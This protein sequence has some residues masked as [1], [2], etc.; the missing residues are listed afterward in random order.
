[1]SRKVDKHKSTPACSWTHISNTRTLFPLHIIR[2]ELLLITAPR[3]FLHVITHWQADYE[4]EEERRPSRR[5]DMCSC[6]GPGCGISP[7]Q[8][9]T[10]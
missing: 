5:R 9:N 1:M 4:Q 7:E 3:S 8:N 2:P 10:S 6:Y